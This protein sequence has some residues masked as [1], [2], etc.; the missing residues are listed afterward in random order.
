[1]SLRVYPVRTAGWRDANAQIMR[2]GGYKFT[3]LRL[4]KLSSVDKWN[5]PTF[6]LCSFCFFLFLVSTA[7]SLEI[8]L[9]YEKSVLVRENADIDCTVNNIKLKSVQNKLQFI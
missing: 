2:V 6:E 7:L 1:M 8:K 4:A 3:R 9:R 5:S